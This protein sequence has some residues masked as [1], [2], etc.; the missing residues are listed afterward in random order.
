LPEQVELPQLLLLAEPVQEKPE[1]SL[2]GGAAAVLVELGEERV[3]V[4]HLQKLAGAQALGE[5][6]HEACLS[7]PDGAFHREVAGGISVLAHPGTPTRDVD[8]PDPFPF[9]RSG[10]TQITQADFP[11][12]TAAVRDKAVRV[13][14]SGSDRLERDAR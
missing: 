12:I 8:V 13:L 10:S 11:A 1:L 2:E 7:H 9:L 5:L 6:V 14:G 3:V 4:R